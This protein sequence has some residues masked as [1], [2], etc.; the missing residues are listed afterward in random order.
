MPQSRLIYLVDDSKDYRFLVEQVFKMFLPQHQ[1]R[2]FADGSELADDL[3]LLAAQH[4]V[5]PRVIILDIDMPVL[6][7]F[8]TLMRLKNHDY[9]KAVPVIMMTN[10]E[11]AA[12]RHESFRLKASAFSLKPMDIMEIKTVMTAICEHEGDFTA[13]YD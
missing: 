5:L 10:R 1:V 2:F 12:F 4:S 6:N 13:L 9:W 7:G 3:D 11:Q 8:Q